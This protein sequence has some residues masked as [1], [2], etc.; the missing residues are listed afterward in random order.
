MNFVQD[1]LDGFI[2]GACLDLFGMESLDDLPTTSQ[3]PMFIELQTPEEQY[4][5]IHKLASQLLNVYV[6]LNEGNK[7]NFVNIP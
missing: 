1:C 5:Y 7:T 6:K 4:A 3:I 2:L